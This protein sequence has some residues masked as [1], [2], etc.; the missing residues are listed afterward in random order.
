MTSCTCRFSAV[1]QAQVQH[2]LRQHLHGRLV[3]GA[4]GQAGRT[5]PAPAR[6]QH[7]FIQAFAAR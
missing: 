5:C 7:Q 2:A 6:G 1:Q 4:V 3:D